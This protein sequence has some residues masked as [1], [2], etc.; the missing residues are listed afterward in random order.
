MSGEQGGALPSVSA[1]AIAFLL[2]CHSRCSVFLG[3][4]KH[5]GTVHLLCF[6]RRVLASWRGSDEKTALAAGGCFLPQP[7]GPVQTVRCRG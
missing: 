1:A 3:A 2:R 7:N 4:S 5:S 6:S